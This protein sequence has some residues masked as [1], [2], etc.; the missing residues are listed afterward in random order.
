MGSRKRS[1]CDIIIRETTYKALPV[2]LI[3]VGVFG[4]TA[5]F[6][7]TLQARQSLPFDWVKG[8]CLVLLSLLSL[9]L[10]GL[11]CVRVRDK[12][13]RPEDEENGRGNAGEPS[14]ATFAAATAAAAAVELADVN[15]P[16][17]HIPP[18]QR[19]SRP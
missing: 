7:W 13:K 11:L 18:F 10:V 15:K 9:F 1:K 6:I 16:K 8:F 2:L 3:I 12:A 14:L 19:E 17:R 4:T 5:V